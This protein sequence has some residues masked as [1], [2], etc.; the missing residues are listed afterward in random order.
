M[1]IRH[2]FLLF[3]AFLCAQSAQALETR[4]AVFI[5]AERGNFDETPLAYATEDARRMQQA[6]EDVGGVLPENALVLE[7]PNADR[8]RDALARVNAR[9]RAEQQDHSFLIVYYSGHA[10]TESLHLGGTTLPWEEFKNITAGSAAKIRLVILDTCRS[11]S[12][13]RVKGT[14]LVAPFALQEP[15]PAEGFAILAA[16]AAGEDAQESDNIKASFFTH[17]FL[18]GLMGAADVN[19]DGTV[20]LRE[21]YDYASERTISSTAQTLAGAQHPT[22]LY[23]L[24]G[25]S[26][27][28]LSQPIQNEKMVQLNVKE[29]GHYFFHE[30]NE[31]GRLVLEAQTR[32][33]QQ[34]LWLP[35]GKY[36]VRQ[37]QRDRFYEGKIELAAGTS[38]SLQ[39]EDLSAIEYARFVRKGGAQN[40]AYQLSLWAFNHA[41]LIEA[42][43]SVWGGAVQMAIELQQISLDFRA[44][45]GRNHINQ[46]PIRG[47]ID[48]FALMGGIRSVF[49]VGPFAISPGLRVG[50]L[51]M[52]QSYESTRIT[53]ARQQLVPIL[54]TLLRVDLVVGF[55][56]FVSAEAGI[57][58][59]YTEIRQDGA[60]TENLARVSPLVSLG[61]GRFF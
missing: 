42:Y 3:T 5:G 17:H 1:N 12:A 55:G 7:N 58:A 19:A 48:N 46:T 20:T 23:E 53:P 41:S 25:R 54:D 21:N 52:L 29:P 15:H 36:F 37:R 14:K 39:Q 32:T 4:Y 35:A 22:Y 61:F 33:P 49:D 56:F 9:I 51:Y 44:E 16:T 59:G 45:Y 24:K 27:I 60:Q 43:P 57:R 34:M 50:G 26:D 28:R 47:T 38:Q 30:E 6:F 10:D 18:S 40:T 11:G 2:C 13:T 31:E 8:V